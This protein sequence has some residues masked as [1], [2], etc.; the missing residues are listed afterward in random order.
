MLKI[1][2]YLQGFVLLALLIYA[3]PRLI[4]NIKKQ[5]SHKIEKHH[6]IGYLYIDNK[7][8][9]A[10]FYRKHLTNYF[11][12]SSMKAILIKIESDGGAAGSCQALAHEIEYLKKEY[13]KPII[14]YV[15]NICTSGAYQIAAATDYIIATGSCIIGNIGMNV[16][17]AFT[18]SDTLDANYEQNKDMNQQLNTNIQKISENMYQQTTKEIASKRHLQ[19]NKI[20][21]WGQGQLFTG[22][23]AYDLKLVDAIGSKTTAINLLKK[24]I[25]PSDLAIE[26]ITPYIPNI[27]EKNFNN[28]HD[29]DDD[30]DINTS[31]YFSSWISDFYHK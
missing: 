18:N 27:I 23:Q 9:N 16:I 17:P 10:S 25:I 28:Y 15:E 22:Q 29:E 14:C 3:A 31:S 30:L 1:N 4:H 13:P 19:L 6:K 20:D 5:W 26:W 8:K 21:Q 24:N 12:D 7:I 2:N 11:K